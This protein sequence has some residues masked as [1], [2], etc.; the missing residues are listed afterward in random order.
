MEDLL[1]VVVLVLGRTLF[2]VWCSAFFGCSRHS[3]FGLEPNTDVRKSSMF[4]LNVRRTFPNIYMPRKWQIPFNFTLFSSI[5]LASKIKLQNIWICTLF[6]ALFTIFSPVW[7]SVCRDAIGHLSLHQDIQHSGHH[8]T[9]DG[10]SWALKIYTCAVT[11]W[12]TASGEVNN[13][14]KIVISELLCRVALIL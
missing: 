11:E 14:W 5:F 7:L 8:R 6:I 1:G 10:K 13:M 9:I 12:K 2:E 3:K 4:D